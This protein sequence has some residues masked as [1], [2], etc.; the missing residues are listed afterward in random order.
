MNDKFK[1]NI[2]SIYEDKKLSNDQLDKLFSIQEEKKNKNIF[3]LLFSRSALA[4]FS[5]VL[6]AFISFQTLKP[7]PNIEELIIQEIAYNHNKQMSPELLSADLSKVQTYLKSLNFAL[8]DSPKLSHL[9]LVGGRYC[10]IQGKVAAQLKYT[11]NSQGASTIYQTAMPKVLRDK[12]FQQYESS[13]Q[14]VHVKIWHEKGILFGKAT[15][16]L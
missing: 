8:V 12:K 9:E 15:S 16:D 1:K 6:I 13:Y 7:T 10:S 11:S 5:V 4:L 2:Q 3:S 14:G